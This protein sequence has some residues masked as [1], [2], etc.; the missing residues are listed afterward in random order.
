MKNPYLILTVLIMV[1]FPTLAQVASEPDFRFGNVS[2]YNLNRGDQITFND[3]GIELLGTDHHYARIR[4]DGDTI[5]LKTARRSP[6]LTMMNVQIFLADSRAVKSLAGNSLIHGLLR[7]DILLGVAMPHVPLMDPAIFGFPVSY[8]QGFLWRT[9]EDTYMFSWQAGAESG[10]PQER[11]YA[12]VGI[13]MRDSRA[14][15]KN[16]VL[17]VENGR[18]IWVESRIPGTVEPRAALCIQ[19]ES[20]PGIYYI[21]EQL[22]NDGLMVK[23]GQRVTKGDGL[24]YAWGEG[25]W[26]HLRL[27]VVFSDSIPAYASRHNYTLNY[28]PQLL[29]LYFGRQPVF[30]HSFSKGQLYFGRP[31]HL[32]GNAKNISG[33]EEYHGTGWLLGPWNP[34]DKV[35]WVSTRR[36]GNA[37]LRK[38]LFPGQRAECTNPAD[39]YEF[40]INVKNGTY[41]IRALLGDYLLPSWQK[42]EFEGVNAGT[43]KREAGDL[44]WT[45][46]RIVRVNDSKLTVR[47]YTDGT[48]VAGISEIVFQQAVL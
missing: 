2:Y 26:N 1:C 47:I 4:V 11:S 12:G 18:V 15:K 25:S 14:M 27:G 37:R 21:Y 8:T 10:S 9:L 44:V 33:F 23:R 38:T 28:Y 36:S 40:E 34:A 32:N 45:N 13:D 5:W 20:M 41:R 30:S 7:A 16:M 35:E 22:H 19:S 6:A 29:D 39:Y 3:T 42:V 48:H 43:F 17:A 31:A 24:G 46:E